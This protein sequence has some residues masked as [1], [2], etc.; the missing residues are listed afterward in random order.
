LK[1][2]VS[3][4][5]FLNRLYVFLTAS[6]L[7]GG[8]I[9]SCGSKGVGTAPPGAEKWPVVVIGAGAGGLGAGATLAQNGVKTLVL[10]Q[11]DKPG[12]YMT[13]FE[14]G[15][16]RFEVSLHMMDGLDENGTTRGAL[17]KLGILDR[18]KPIKIEPIYRLV[19]PDLTLDVPSDLAAYRKVLG[20]KFPG[21]AEGINRLL[22]ELLA[23]GSA[24]EK[25]Q[26]LQDQ[27]FLLR[28]VKYPFVPL[29]AWDLIKN[30]N[31]TLQEIG[32]R[33]IKDPKAKS[34][35][36]QLVNFLGL[37]ASRASG[38]YFAIMWASYHK[39]GAYHFQGGSQA[40]SNALAQVIQEKGGEVRLNTRVKK[41]LI[42]EGKA[43]GVE[44]E[45]GQKIYAD[46]VIS[47]ANGY[48][49][50]ID[51]VG[52]QNLSSKFVKYVKGLE[53]G[54]S[55]TEV[56]LG[57][58]LDLS[59]IGLGGIGEIFYNPDYD[60][61]GQWKNNLAMKIDDKVSLGIA[62]YSNTDPTCAP[63]GKSVV[64]LTLITP[65]DWKNRWQSGEG[66][67]AYHN[68]KNQVADRMIAIA[69]KT[70]PGIR[71]AIE[72]MEVGSPLTMER[73]T[74]NYKGSFMGWAPTPAQS[75]L[76]RMRFTGP[77]K[78]LYLA[79]SWSF[80]GGGQSAS[81]ISGQMTG[82]MVSDR[83]D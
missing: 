77:I 75:M 68:L 63:P 11:H 81:L 47:N 41:I 4:K 48:S 66:G 29:M 80:P 72:V 76:K 2:S 31:A 36:F 15:D 38:A 10:E 73:Y 32:D 12:G 37:P 67:E 30:R 43:V 58:N 25:L 8:M 3:A 16:Y 22:D 23:I 45:K 33:Y 21:S 6:F 9:L 61:E 53:P 71:N 28:W 17:K 56:Y 39:Y 27:F 44:T 60:A 65:Y 35:V 40:V 14:R 49:T 42:Q 24:T 1:T 64:V 50:Y 7:L 51:M 59:K 19:Y 52:E 55:V 70:I 62:L 83:I 82:Q 54:I 13:A 74:L 79:G 46:Y 69:E 34:T 5:G 78:N 57:L 26:K 20:E 18:V